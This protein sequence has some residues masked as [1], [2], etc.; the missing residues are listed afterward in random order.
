ML[1]VSDTNYRHQTAF[2]EALEL[3]LN[4]SAAGTCQTDQLGCEKTALGLTEEKREDT[5][6]C[7]REQRVCQARPLGLRSRSGFSGGSPSWSPG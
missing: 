1:L 2:D 4:G 5:L 3:A 7:G 6:L